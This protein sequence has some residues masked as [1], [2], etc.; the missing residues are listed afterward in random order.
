MNKNPTPWGFSRKT[1]IVL[2]RFCLG[3]K[4]LLRLLQITQIKWCLIKG[5]GRVGREIDSDRF[6]KKCWFFGP[7]EG[8]TS[9]LPLWV[10]TLGDKKLQITHKNFFL[11]FIWQKKTIDIEVNFFLFSGCWHI[12][13]PS[14]GRYAWKKIILLKISGYRPKLVQG[15]ILKGWAAT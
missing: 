9:N 10:F 3:D 8:G 7:A 6:V 2:P 15:S 14:A 11:F 12:R 13:G 4:V 1:P 5:C